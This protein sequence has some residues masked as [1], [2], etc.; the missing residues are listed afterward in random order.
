M[1]KSCL[2][3]GAFIESDVVTVAACK[4]SKCVKFVLIDKYVSL[5]CVIGNACEVCLCE[6]L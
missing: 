5:E 3:S 1:I 6:R 2:L 4:N